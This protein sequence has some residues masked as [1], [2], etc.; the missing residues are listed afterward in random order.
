MIDFVQELFNMVKEFIVSHAMIAKEAL[1][2]ISE[3]TREETLLH[4]SFGEIRVFRI[5]MDS[6]FE[7]DHVFKKLKKLKLVLGI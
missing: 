6:I 4:Y 3:H 2:L 7:E 5:G 1:S